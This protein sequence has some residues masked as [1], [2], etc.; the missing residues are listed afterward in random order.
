MLK[1]VLHSLIVVAFLGI[2]FV[3]GINADKRKNTLQEDGVGMDMIEDTSSLDFEIM[4]YIE[5]SNEFI[6]VNVNQINEMI[7]RN[8]TFILYTGRV[9]CQWC[10]KIVP[11]LYDVQKDNDL[12]VYYLDS[13]NTKVDEQIQEFRTMYEIESVPS[14]IKF[15]ENG[16]W[17]KIVFDEKATRDQIYK[18][19]NKSIDITYKNN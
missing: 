18:D 15:K 5:F 13:E 12:V 10:R 17:E 7:N 16:A 1:K 9:T 14:I 11:I 19:I 4:A 8:E 3:G 2:L 6:P